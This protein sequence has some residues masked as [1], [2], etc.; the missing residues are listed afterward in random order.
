MRQVNVQS[1]ACARSLVLVLALVGTVGSAHG[2]EQPPAEVPVAAASGASPS[3]ATGAPGTFLGAPKEWLD[4]VSPEQ[5]YRLMQEKLDAERGGGAPPGW[6]TGLIPV[7]FFGAVVVLVWLVLRH[8]G[9]QE[10]K[11]QET[12]RAMIDKGLEIP[13]ELLAPS[14]R[15]PD[16]PPGFRDLRRAILLICG[17]LGFSLFLGVVGIWETEALRGTGIGLIP[18]FLGLGYFIVWKLGRKGEKRE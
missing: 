16:E 3:S 4:K 2:Q 12:A 6:A 9:Q 5:A 14:P 17:G 1:G 13:K 15:R 18:F 7:A 8:R 10:T 11:R